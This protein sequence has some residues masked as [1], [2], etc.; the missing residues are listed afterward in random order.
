MVEETTMNQRSEPREPDGI[1]A[2]IE[3]L[4]MII[5]SFA[6]AFV[7]KH[8][9]AEAYVIPTG[10][11]APTLLGAHMKARGPSSG[12]E[13]SLG[14]DNRQVSRETGIALPIQ[15]NI[16]VEDPMLSSGP[17]RLA[18]RSDGPQTI[19]F[20]N[21]KVR[22][23]DRIFVQ[24]Y[25][26]SIFQPKRFDVV[27]FK[28]PVDPRQNFIK[29]LI[30]VGNETVW[31]ADGDVF[32][33][34]PEAGPL[35]VFVVQRKPNHVQRAV[36]QP[37][38]HSDFIP[39]RPEAFRWSPPW[40]GT[41]FNLNGR[42]YTSTNGEHSALQWSNDRMPINDRTAYDE[43]QSPTSLS[44]ADLYY[45]SDIR[46]AA[47]IVAASDGLE[48]RIRLQARG[49]EFEAVFG[50]GK[51]VLRMRSLGTVDVVPATRGWETLADLSTDSANFKAG[52]VSNVEFWHV[53]QSLKCWIDDE[54][55]AEGVYDWDAR[56]RLI[57]ATGLDP[58]DAPQ[59]SSY[60][61]EFR[62]PKYK[63]RRPEIRWEFEGSK[64]ALHH[65][66]LDRDLFY[67]PTY[68]RESGKPALGT[69][70]SNLVHLDHDQFFMCGD[71]SPA[72][73]D[74]RTW[75]PPAPW[76]EHRFNGNQG[77]VPRELIL[78]KAF[79]VYYPSP[80]GLS[81]D[82]VRFIPNFGQMRLIR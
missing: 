24:R 13:F 63:P 47:G 72:S 14:P 6:I 30:G 75:D 21:A 58:V 27:V 41:N 57:A 44:R 32:T 11:M 33:G 31:L 77:I 35:D 74:G 67:R 51:I 56:T 42:Y 45:V 39:I 76:I 59:R 23:G 1:S 60:G 52:Q 25:L 50:R 81:D 54:L 2:V 82:G 80:E 15:K 10:S 36:W 12:Y 4:Q 40:D 62:N 61:N 53:D 9:V 3:T 8:F 69:Y 48:S 28:Y 78:G 37:V 71:N 64:V 19:S 34:L 43:A 66:E 55:V 29:R 22:M 79:F 38:Y 16:V 65:V 46:L 26:Y 17:L 20:T 5:I 73:N 7:F 70:P 18:N 68:Y 49:H